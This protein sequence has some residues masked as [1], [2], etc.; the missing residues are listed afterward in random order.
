M[1]SMDRRYLE[2]LRRRIRDF[3]VRRELRP[4]E[5]AVCIK[6]VDWFPEEDYRSAGEFLDKMSRILRGRSEKGRT[7]IQSCLRF[8]MVTSASQHVRYKLV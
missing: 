5:E 4:S 2:R 7:T 1:N 6:I 8:W 3:Q